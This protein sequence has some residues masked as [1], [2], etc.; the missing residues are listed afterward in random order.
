MR[1][2]IKPIDSFLYFLEWTPPES[3][4]EIIFL[5]KN[6]FHKIAEC[7]WYINALIEKP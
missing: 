5:Q 2:I 6:N 1:W 4:T 3:N 7:N